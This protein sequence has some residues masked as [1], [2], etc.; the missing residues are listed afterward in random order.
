MRAIS[1]PEWR[2]PLN[3]I[4]LLLDSEGL[5][6]SWLAKANDIPSSVLCY[7]GPP[8]LF[9]PFQVVWKVEVGICQSHGHIQAA[10]ECPQG[11]FILNSACAG[12][13]QG[14]NPAYTPA[15]S[16]P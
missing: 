16:T 9:C 8:L 3:N 6:D 10:A 2:C 14:G 15:V 7:A 11:T 12:Y 13:K 5:C 1:L 4:A